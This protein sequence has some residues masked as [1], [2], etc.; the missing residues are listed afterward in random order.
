MR[1]IRAAAVQYNHAPGDKAFNFER[2]RSFVEDAS[3]QKVDLIAFPEMC[4]SGYWHVR[5]LSRAEIAQVL[6]IP[7]SVVKSRL[8][9]GLQNLRKHSSLV[10][11]R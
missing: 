10:S 2:I 7:E 4:I 5:K 6:D 1:R 9:E 3:A 8:Y 11:D